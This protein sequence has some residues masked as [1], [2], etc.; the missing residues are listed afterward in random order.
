MM[1]TNK[2]TI[3]GFSNPETKEIYEQ[4]WNGDASL[5]Q[6][7]ENGEQCGGCSFFAE[8]NEDYGLCCNK[9]SRQLT[10]TVFEHFTCSAYA[11]EGWGP[12]SFT[13]N[14]D[15]WCRC[16]GEPIYRT[17]TLIIALLARDSLDDELRSHLRALRRYIAEQKKA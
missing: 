17:I 8:F 14:E 11:G 12:H 10:E 7:Y 5:K 3:T 9:D 16:Q 13:Y 4:N 1:N 2:I 6:Q 15:L